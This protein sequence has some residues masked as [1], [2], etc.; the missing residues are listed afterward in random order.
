MNLFKKLIRIGG[1]VGMRECP[2]CGAK[3]RERSERW[4]P[5]GRDGSDVLV[6]KCPKCGH[7]ERIVWR[8]GV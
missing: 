2:R 4:P 3:M 8:M 6:A 7:E 1:A 5:F